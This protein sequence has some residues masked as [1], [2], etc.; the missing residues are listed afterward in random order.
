MLHLRHRTS[1]FQPVTVTCELKSYQDLVAGPNDRGYIEVV[2]SSFWPRLDCGC[3]LVM[4]VN[5]EGQL[6]RLP[7]N[8]MAT[9]LGL[10]VG[11]TSTIY[12]DVF[13]VGEGLV[14]T[15]D[16]PEPDFIPVPTDFLMPVDV[17]PLTARDTL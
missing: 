17:S 5:E 4:V 7:I 8:S 10:M 13:F 14:Q 12:G 3:R 9:Y 2:R 15:P 1:Q 16:G 11:Q 6:Y